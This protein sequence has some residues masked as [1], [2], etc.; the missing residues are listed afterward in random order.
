LSGPHVESIG[1]LGVPTF[2]ISCPTRT[3]C[4][5]VSDDGAVILNATT[6]AKGYP[7]AYQH[8]I[9][10]HWQSVSCSS[11]TFCMAGGG[12]V[13]G[14]QDG[15][16]VVASWNGF[17]WSVVH[18]VLPDIPSEFKTQI[19]S[20]SCTGPTFCIAGDQDERVLQW[21]GKRWFS[22]QAF[23][24]G[25]DS[26]SASCPSPSFCLSPG[27]FSNSTF[28]WDG[29][30]WQLSDPSA[31]SSTFGFVFV[32]CLSRTNCVGLSN[33]GTAQR[34]N[35]RVWGKVTQ[36]FSDRSDGVQGI[37][38]SSAGFCEAVTSGDHFIDIY[39]PHKPPRLPVLCGSLVCKATTT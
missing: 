13:G 16:G 24:G 6:G 14:P 28:A 21:N 10:T 12:L 39:N 38:C 35:G 8:A 33:V 23:D 15:A 17:G 27:T 31:L 26:F 2:G 9:T 30:S 20:M 4:A 25:L 37:A 34:W 36:L 3:F 19:S 22:P 7:L 1:S 18:V 11:P 32:S 5:A 29:R